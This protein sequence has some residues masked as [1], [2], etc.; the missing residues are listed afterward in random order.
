MPISSPEDL[1]SRV[2]PHTATMPWNLSQ[3]LSARPTDR[4]LI[5]QY[6][7]R[8]FSPEDLAFVQYNLYLVIDLMFGFVRNYPREPFDSDLSPS[9]DNCLAGGFSWDRFNAQ[10]EHVLDQFS[11]QNNIRRFNARGHPSSGPNTLGLE[12]YGGVMNDYLELEQL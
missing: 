10:F 6:A 11:H 8:T 1:L 7:V 9:Q 12:D 2:D 3:W 5:L 4:D